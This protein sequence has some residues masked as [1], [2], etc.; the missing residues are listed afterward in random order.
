MSRALSKSTLTFEYN[1]EHT[2]VY[3][4]VVQRDS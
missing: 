2:G 1:V 3:D 4:Y